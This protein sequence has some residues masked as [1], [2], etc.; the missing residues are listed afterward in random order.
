MTDISHNLAYL[1][2]TQADT[3]PDRILYIHGSEAIS[4]QS[5]WN[6]VGRLSAALKSL[7]IEKGSRIMLML[8]N[9]PE[10]IIAYYAVLSVGAVVVPTN[11]MLRAREL[12]Y[13]LEDC[14]ARA[15]I[16]DK[17][18]LEDITSA[19]GSLVTLRHSIFKGE[20]LPDGILAFDSLLEGHESL[21]EPEMVASSDTAVI[22]YTAGITGRPK[23]AE[24]THRSLTGN[25]RVCANLLQVRPRDRLLGLLPFFHAFGQTAVMN[26][27]LAAGASVVLLSDF[28]PEGIMKAVQEHKITIFLATPSMYN[29]IE[30]HP[31]TDQY[32]FNSVRYCV[33]GGHALKPELLTAFEKKFSTEILEGY[34]LCETTAVATFSHLHLG[35]RPGSI[36]TPIEGVEIKILND[37]GD[38]VVAGQ[39]GE[40]VIRSDYLMK[41]YLNRPEATAEVLRDGWFYTGDLAR[42]DENGYLYILDRK[43]D[44]IIK[45]GFNVY[46]AEIEELLLSYPG[47]K[48]A[49]V[50]SISD[51]VQGEEIKACIVCDGDSDVTA[52]RLAAYCRERLARYKCPRYIQFYQQLPKS[53]NGRI[54]RKKLREAE[55]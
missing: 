21:P 37:A 23:G 9:V 43:T 52:E 24:L 20:D 4:A 35:S 41:G 6:S 13:L 14:E 26:T 33:S 30:S 34:G 1:L 49:A 51:P 10:Y 39:V 38:E 11:W 7:G 22:L 5:I 17:A 40:I 2:K 42:E 45:G 3:H 32:D 47:I 36:G 25:A 16:A 53:P 46:P 54:L 19:S 31:R 27:A 12:H 50:I 8:P 29:L 55:S 48:E 44:M 15:I 28:S 18:N